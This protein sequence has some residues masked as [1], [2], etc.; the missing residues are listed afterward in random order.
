MTEVE[1]R[2]LDVRLAK[3]MGYRAILMQP[4]E[5]GG[6]VYWVLHDPDGKRMPVSNMTPGVT[7][8]VVPPAATIAWQQECPRFSADGAAMLA[9]MQW[10]LANGWTYHVG[11]GGHDAGR[12][13]AYVW[14]TVDVAVQGSA[15]G[16]S[17][18]LVLA[19]AADTV[20]RNDAHGE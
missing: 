10:L 17:P 13:E 15:E 19:L 5:P 2:A 4:Y 11:N 20:L 18:P 12:L 16:T 6:P 7:H 3:A 14:R 9:L 1:L 8:Y